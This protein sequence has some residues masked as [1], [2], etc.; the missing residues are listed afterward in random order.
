MNDA[1]RSGLFIKDVNDNVYLSK[2]GL[3]V[4]EDLAVKHNIV[5]KKDK[6]YKITP[7]FIA[8]IDRA[9]KDPNLDEQF[10]QYKSLSTTSALVMVYLKD[11]KFVSAAEGLVLCLFMEIYVFSILKKG[12]ADKETIRDLVSAEDTRASLKK[13]K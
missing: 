8:F 4:A 2:Q 7:E 6:G 10:E 12:G 3:K 1:S 9:S 13:W 5:T 11:V